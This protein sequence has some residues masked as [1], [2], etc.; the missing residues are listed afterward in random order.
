M[1]RL[2][3]TQ[4]QKAQNEQDDDNQSDDVNYRVHKRP[5]LWQRIGVRPHLTY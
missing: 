1:S 3:S 2:G 4:A 5:T